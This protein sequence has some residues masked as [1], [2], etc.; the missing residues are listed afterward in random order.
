MSVGIFEFLKMADN[1]SI[2]ELKRK[3]KHLNYI[4]NKQFV[5]RRLRQHY[6][7]ITGRITE[8]SMESLS[9]QAALLLSSLVP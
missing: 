5:T 4:I 9:K 6:A 2:I 3:E 1:L 7:H 8:Y